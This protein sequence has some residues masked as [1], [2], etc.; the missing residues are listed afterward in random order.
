[1]ALPRARRPPTVFTE[2]T[3]SN[4]L[5]NRD[6]MTYLRNTGI[7]TRGPASFKKR[8]RSLFLQRL[9]KVIRAILDGK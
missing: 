5:A 9:D 7:D 1:V 4:A 8:D 3:I 2:A 6:I